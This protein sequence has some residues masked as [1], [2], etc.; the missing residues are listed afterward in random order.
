VASASNSPVTVRL[1]TREDIDAF[2]ALDAKPTIRA[3]VA[4]KEGRIIGLGGVALSRGRWYAFADLP[5]EIRPHKML[6]ARA[7]KRFL[8]EAR[9]DGIRFIYAKASE[10]EPRAIR[11]LTSLGFEY[12]PRPNDFPEHD[13]RWSSG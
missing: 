9:R 2:V 10:T 4:E 7:A 5:D 11:W 13:Y 8:E 3:L 12:S 1:A 6:I